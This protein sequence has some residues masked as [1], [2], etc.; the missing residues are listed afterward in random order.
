MS[1]EGMHIRFGAD[2]IAAIQLEGK[3]RSRGVTSDGEALLA[4]LRCLYFL[5]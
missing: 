1:W 3:V 2:V 5:L 4:R